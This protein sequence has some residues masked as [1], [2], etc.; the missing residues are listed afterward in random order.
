M[1]RAAEIALAEVEAELLKAPA[2]KKYLIRREGL[3][4]TL[5]LFKELESR[6]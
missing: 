2:E 4:K 3:V 6:Q 1:V 5:A